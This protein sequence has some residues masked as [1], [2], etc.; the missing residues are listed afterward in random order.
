M[1]MLHTN[2][3]NESNGSHRW[4]TKAKSLVIAKISTP[5]RE[6]PDLK[7]PTTGELVTTDFAK[8]NILGSYFRLTQCTNPMPEHN[9][10]HGQLAGC[11]DG[12][13]TFCC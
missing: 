3:T 7:D 11:K 6:V 8:A 5:R 9:Y 2:L 10:V 1:S 13:G 4:W 12:T